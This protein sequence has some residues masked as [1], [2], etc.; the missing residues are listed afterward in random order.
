MR[1]GYFVRSSPFLI[2][3]VVTAISI[4]CSA[5]QSSK[6]PATGSE[7]KKEP[8]LRD[9]GSKVFQST[10]V[11][12]LKLEI[13]DKAI[14]KIQAGHRP[15]VR[16]KLTELGHASYESIGIK[17][18]G[19]AGSYQGFDGKPGFTVNMDKYRKKQS[20]H[21][22]DKFHLNNAVQDETYL[23]EWLGHE[24][25]EAAHYPAA[26]VKH[27][28]LTINDRPP[29]LYVFRETY[30]GLFLERA[31]RRPTGNLY[32]S[33]AG[34]ELDGELE[35]DAGLGGDD[36]SDLRRVI[37]A[38]RIEDPKERYEQMNKYIDIDRFMTFMALERMVCHWDGY[39]VGMNNY[40]LYFDPESD[41]AVF[42]PHGM[43]QIFGDVGMSLFEFSDTLVATQIL[44]ND[45]W[46]AQYRARVRELLPIFNPP[47]ALIDKV[48]AAAQRLLPSLQR[49]GE[50]AVE[51]HRNLV[52]ELKQR[53]RDRAANL[54]EQLEQD[55]PSP[56][57]I[58]ESQALP[59]WFPTKDAEEIDVESTSD[60][61]VAAER[62]CGWKFAFPPII[63]A[64]V[65][66]DLDFYWGAANTVSRGAIASLSLYRSTM[67]ILR[68]LCW[69]PSYPN[70]GQLGMVKPIGWK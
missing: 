52:E 55:P 15:Y 12:E 10:G 39:T 61:Q 49:L 25:F 34:Q 23:N 19:A 26:R 45:D 41:R 66:G 47:D 67:R 21:G 62:L 3:C 16:A 40:R 33:G 37:E 36:R 30:D 50:E 43:D 44:G 6:A 51:A 7:A 65:L 56:L 4:G 13:D 28:M 27:A 22:L 70:N 1:L 31:F 2:L 58:E 63:L 9:R 60:E 18:K 14:E 32:D 5:S 29:A 46:R 64:Q 57:T 53:I 38:I 11:H 48:D 68:P 20:F 59:D 17:L 35:K 54:V 24:V 69:V 8:A 42:L